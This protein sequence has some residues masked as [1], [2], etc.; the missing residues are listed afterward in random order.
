MTRRATLGMSAPPEVV[1]S[2]ATDPDRQGAWL[3][4][5]FDLGPASASSAAF[6]V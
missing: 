1:F 6:E 3:P 2:T 5:G 4:S